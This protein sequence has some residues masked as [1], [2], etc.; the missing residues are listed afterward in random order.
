VPVAVI[1]CARV[2]GWGFSWVWARV[3]QKN[4]RA[5]HADP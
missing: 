4:P 3:A 5:T 1:S 2:F